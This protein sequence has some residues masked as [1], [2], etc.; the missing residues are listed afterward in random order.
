MR[1]EF[2][3]QIIQ[4]IL[5]NFDIQSEIYELESTLQKNGLK[6]LNNIKKTLL[7]LKKF[8]DRQIIFFIF[9]KAKILEFV[10]I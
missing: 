3:K 10:H 8:K 7:A 4:M 2:E 9:L 5:K 6:R 1:E